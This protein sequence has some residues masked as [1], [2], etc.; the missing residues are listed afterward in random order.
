MRKY[1]SVS[2]LIKKYPD[3]KYYVIF[4]ERTNGKTFSSLEY[5]LENL[6]SN[7]EEFAYVRRFGEDIKKK[8]M[9][10][11]FN[12]L[13][14]EGII[15]KI[16]N[17]KYADVTFGSNTFYLE[18][19]DKSSQ[20]KLGYAFD[21]NSMEHYKSVS[22]PLVSTIIFDE[23]ISR[24]GYLPNE[25]VLFMNTLSTI[26]RD[27]DNVKVIML[28]NTVNK[29]CPYFNEMGLTHVKEQ[30]QGS[31][32]VYTY[33][34][35]GLKVIVDY[36]QS[37]NKFGGKKSDVY[38]AFDN[39]HLQMI[40]KG[41]WEIGIYPHLNI[42]IRPI[43]VIANFFVIFDTAMLHGEVV[44]RDDNYLIFIHEKTTPL[45]NPKE[46]IVYTDFPQEQWNYRLGFGYRDKLTLF[47]L[48]CMAENRIFYS[49]NEAGEVFRNYIEWSS[50]FSKTIGG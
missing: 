31:T 39:P 47:I 49:T 1:Y 17:G 41:S 20:L 18:P 10:N 9:S 16:S 4:G 42:K 24:Q 26:I 28:G 23:F 43:D 14:T 22:Y 29:Y 37:A 11:L 27:R 19:S 2:K 48:R 32:D 33:G 5:S 30:E 25:F 3:A 50:K 34:E 7:G 44:V 45:K 46:D 21:L 13:V 15:Q 35:S 12:A 8:N 6:I 36:C 40:T 38:F